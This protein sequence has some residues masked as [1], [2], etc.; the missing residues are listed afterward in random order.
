[1]VE[2]LADEA[3][4]PLGSALGAYER[5][6]EIRCEGTRVATIKWGG[7]NPDPHVQ[8]TSEDAPALADLLRSEG[9]AHRVS[10]VDVCSDIR[11]QQAL[12]PV[13]E[14]ARFLS[15]G[16]KRKRLLMHD[17]DDLAAGMTYRVGSVKSEHYVR[18]YDKGA[19][20]GTGADHARVELQARPSNRE[21]KEWAAM[22]SPEE[23][24][25]MSRL[26]RDLAPVIAIEV[27]MGLKR[28]ERLADDERAYQV[29]LDQY[30]NILRRRFQALGGDLE[31][32]ALDIVQR[33]DAEAAE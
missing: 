32:F 19:E 10:R 26:V 33:I 29:M 13:I 28:T 31:A 7:I 16:P 14:I 15:Q 23:V 2:A 9:I 3:P 4:K 6:M 11:D 8:A 24:F 1:M 5:G 18:I 20:S 21:R 27:G 22:A 12:E 25:G 17:P 30:Q